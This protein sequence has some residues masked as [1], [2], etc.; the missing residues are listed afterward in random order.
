MVLIFLAVVLD[1]TR[2]TLGIKNGVKL[3]ETRGYRILQRYDWLAVLDASC[4][5]KGNKLVAL[6]RFWC[7]AQGSTLHSLSQE[8]WEQSRGN[9]CHLISHVIQA[10]EGF[11]I[12]PST[13]A[14]P[15]V[16]GSVS[17]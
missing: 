16:H 11:F 1:E 5:G 12:P 2:Y 17:T 14:T 3:S 6:V 10:D 4:P 9:Y 13:S 15:H 8:Q 7:I